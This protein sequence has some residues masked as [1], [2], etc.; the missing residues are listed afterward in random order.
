[1]ISLQTP[2]AT[3]MSHPLV[4]WPRGIPKKVLSLK[5]A[6]ERTIL[7]CKHISQHTARA[8]FHQAILLLQNRKFQNVVVECLPH[9]A[10]R[11]VWIAWLY[12]SVIQGQT[13]RGLI[14]RNKVC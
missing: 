9:A 13:P 6:R 8:P 7:I 14:P 3:W 11:L 2:F 1:M 4:T 12:A 10:T 5:L